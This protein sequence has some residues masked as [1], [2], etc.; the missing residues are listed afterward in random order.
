MRNDT[1]EVSS[2]LTRKYIHEESLLVKSE[3]NVTQQLNCRL[4]VGLHCS[5]ICNLPTHCNC[6]LFKTLK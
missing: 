5:F 4:K 2:E 1:L 3:R 6:L